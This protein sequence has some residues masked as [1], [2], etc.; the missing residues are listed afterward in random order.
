MGARLPSP[1]LA[2]LPA[3]AVW[4]IAEIVQRIR[5][6]GD[7]RAVVHVNFCLIGAGS[8]GEALTKARALGKDG[9]VRYRNPAG[10]Q[11]SIEFLGLRD[12]NVVHDDLE[13]GAELLYEEH[14]GLGD[15]AARELVRPRRALSVFR[16]IRPSPGPDY[17][18]GGILEEAGR[19][20]GGGSV[21]GRGRARGS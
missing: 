21:R 19:M 18:A 5:V 6:E 7:R 20:V 11:V 9:E 10:R 8:P 15:A 1:P 16:P 12:L 4:Y 14:V 13:D 2:D 17:A 3:G